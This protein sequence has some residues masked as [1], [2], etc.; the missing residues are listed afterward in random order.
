MSLSRGRVFDHVVFIMFE[1]EYRTYVKKNPY[2]RDLARQGAELANSFGVMHPSNT[3]YVASIAGEICNIT[4]DPFFY[5]FMPHPPNLPPPPQPLSQE[6]LADRLTSKGLSWKAY[7]ESYKPVAFPPQLTPVMSQ[8]DPTKV[9]E[10]A[11]VRQTILDYPPYMN[12]HNAFVRFQS[13]MEDE[14][15]WRRIQSS[16]DFLRDALNGTLPEYSWL[17]PDVW[18]DGHFLWGTLDE[19]DRREA[20]IDQQA[21][22]L[23]SF[24]SVLNFP[25]PDSRLPPRTLVVVTYDES[26]F[27]KAYQTVENDASEYDGPNQIYT[28]L[29]GDMIVPGTVEREGY[30][31]YSLLRTVE[32][33]F[34]LGDLGK[35]D[36][37][38]NWLR[39][40]WGQRFQWASPSATPI[41]STRCLA[42]TGMGDDLFVVHGPAGGDGLVQRVH[43]GGGW[44]VEQAVP[45]PAGVSAVALA[46]CA[47][48]LLLVCSA[49]D[50]LSALTYSPGSGWS[51]PAPLVAQPGG[52]FALT[53]FTDDGDRTEKVML[54]YRTT[55][56]GIS[57]QLYA[58]GSWAAPVDTGHTTDGDL[59]LA[60]LGSSLYLIHKAT[61][62]EEM[63]VISYNTADCNVITAS[64]G[65]DDTTR[66]AWSPSEYPVAHFSFGPNRSTP[67]EGEPLLRPYRGAGPMAAA[68]L[69]GVIHLTHPRPDDAHLQSQTFSISGIL[70][71]L[72]PV[73]YNAGATGN[74]NGFGTLAEAGW[75]R[76]VTI[77]GASVASGGSLAMARAGSELFLLFQQESGG[78]VQMIAGGYGPT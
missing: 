74:S 29:L 10:T 15:Q 4:S 6:T 18:G 64:S 27:N 17:T 61:G 5:T 43:S 13:I 77:E 58:N 9:D 1:N 73:S 26:D 31:H 33:N 19:P 3:N 54:A 67:A 22:W 35:N 59:V 36:T 16:Y 11:S 23:Q 62:G 71:P 48:R 53:S 8:S 37:E 44:S 72:Q 12:I 42:A 63:N 66:D 57:S 47:G 55:A 56:G 7:M 69:D 45:A 60:V 39:F 38:A 34:E 76:Q 20:L 32:Q 70:T 68:T 2:M 65:D 21:A 30:N 50:G 52:A 14:K 49:A 78:A 46:G 25:G 24:F 28:V 75:S 51:Q 40:L 41:G